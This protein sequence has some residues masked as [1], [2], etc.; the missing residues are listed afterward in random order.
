MAFLMVLNYG[1]VRSV[2][3]DFDLIICM[4]VSL[5]MLHLQLIKSML[6]GFVLVTMIG[7]L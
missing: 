7:I 3:Q 6:S 2:S 5:G 4:C 1:M